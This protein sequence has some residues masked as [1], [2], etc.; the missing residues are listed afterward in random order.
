MGDELIVLKKVL[1]DT[2]QGPILNN[3][4]SQN[5]VTEWRSRWEIGRL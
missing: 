1:F 3:I 2:E 4:V 5:Q